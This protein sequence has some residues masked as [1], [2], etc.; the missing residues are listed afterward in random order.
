MFT[1]KYKMRI[2]GCETREYSRQIGSYTFREFADNYVQFCAYDDIRGDGAPDVWAG[3]TKPKNDYMVPVSIFV[4]N[5]NGSTIASFHFNDTRPVEGEIP[6][7]TAD[8]IDP[9]ELAPA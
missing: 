9:S 1:M 3:Y 2:S 5:D 6:E 8:R 7:Y 4:M